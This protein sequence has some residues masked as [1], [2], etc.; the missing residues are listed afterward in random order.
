MAIGKKVSLS[1]SANG[2]AIEIT[3]L[4]IGFRVHRS[5]TFNNNTAD[6][7]ISNLSTEIIDKFL[8]KGASVT[9]KMGWEDERNGE[10]TTI[11][12]GN[13]LEEV[14]IE[15]VGVDRTTRITA[16]SVR[17]NGNPLGTTKLR[18]SY[19]PD[20]LLSSIIYDVATALGF[21][22]DGLPYAKDIKLPNGFVYMGKASGVMNYIRMM[23]AGRGLSFYT[24]LTDFIIYKLEDGQP[25]TKVDDET[26]YLTF[27]SGLISVGRMERYFEK[28]HYKKVKKK[29]N[30]KIVKENGK[31]VT[32]P[33]PDESQREV[34]P[35]KH[36]IR[37]ECLFHPLIRPNCVVEIH[38]DRIDGTY[39]VDDVE[40]FGDNVD[41]EFNMTLECGNYN[42]PEKELQVI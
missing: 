18:L 17:H 27:Q 4:N 26:V 32:I 3:D 23:L 19:P 20:A 36:K 11:F 12:V 41:G 13:V 30:G 10:L 24:D 42:V 28:I 25:Y 39:L 21:I 5:N 6:F 15:R 29:V 38:T 35:P 33:V 16:K 31:S 34:L 1:I 9:F 40:I 8:V 14:E 7:T 22:V 2:D 37:A